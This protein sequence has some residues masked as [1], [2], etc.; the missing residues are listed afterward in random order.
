MVC[1]ISSINSMIYDLTTR[2]ILDEFPWQ[3][4]WTELTFQQVSS[5]TTGAPLRSSTSQRSLE[6][7]KGMG[8]S[9]VHDDI[10]IIGCIQSYVCV[11]AFVQILNFSFFFQS[12]DFVSLQQIRALFRA[13]QI[14][15]NSQVLG[16]LLEFTKFWGNSLIVSASTS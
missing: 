4:T 14:H 13:V 5:N 12:Q 11:C 15:A 8:T 9:V 7:F 6:D 1:R 3:N 10:N 16:S 2:G